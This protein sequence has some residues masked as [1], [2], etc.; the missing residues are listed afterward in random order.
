[1]A[2]ALANSAGA[3]Q[4]AQV[5][6]RQ[7]TGNLT[8]G[9]SLVRQGE[10]G[11]A[12]KV[13]SLAV[14]KGRQALRDARMEKEKAEEEA[15]KA[16]AQ[17]PVKKTE[18][19]AP[20]PLQKSVSPSKS[21]PSAKPAAAP[22][23]APP[24]LA[25]RYTVTEGE[26]LWTIAARKDI[27]FDSLLWPLIYQANRDQIKDPRQIYPGQVLNIPRDTTE[28]EKEEA[29]EKARKSDIFPVQLLMKARAPQGP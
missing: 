18:P 24:P 9:E 21:A 14:A 28:A 1:M 16:K 11:N 7:A 10:Y 17:P 25:T 12:R 22:A 5:P 29:R 2:V 4:Y 8:K 27:Y 19:P 3:Q 13:L 15:K 26:T 6:Y 23:P 20:K